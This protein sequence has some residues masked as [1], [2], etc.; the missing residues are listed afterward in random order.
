[1]TRPAADF[2]ELATLTAALCDGEITPPQAQRLE[3]LAGQSEAAR[4]YFLQYM[5]LHGE[6][7]WENGDGA[8]AGTTLCDQSN[9]V[10]PARAPSPSFHV[11]PEQTPFV[12]VAPR[13]SS[14]RQ[15]ASVGGRWL[16]RWAVTAA[17]LASVVWIVGGVILS[18]NPFADWRWPPRIARL[19]QTT[20]AQWAD[21]DQT[22]AFSQEL[23]A[24]HVLDLR[25]GLAEIECEGGARLVLQ[26][27]T[28][29]TLES[30]ERLV[31]HRGRIVAH[32]PPA[33]VGFTVQTPTAT[34]VDRGTDFGVVC[35]A[36]RSTEVHVF[37]GAVQVQPTGADAA[38][39]RTELMAG[40]AVRVAAD[41]ADGRL[42]V[43]R[44]PAASSLFV[45]DMPSAAAGSVAQ[46]RRIV[47]AH[48]NLIHHYTFEGATR[49]Q[50]YRDHR[51]EL[52]LRE[53]VMCDGRGGGNLR[54]VVP[55]FDATTNA[56]AP[57]RAE[58][59][60][61]S[62]GVGLE[63]DAMFEP[64]AEMTVELL[65]RFDA[66]QRADG[67]ICAAVAT[68][69]SQRQCG[70]LVAAADNGRPVQLL[71][72]E[73]T[74]IEAEDDFAFI[75]GDWYYM[76]A[77][78]RVEDGKTRVS[79][80]AANL[81]RHESALTRVIRDRLVPGTPPTSRLGI[82]KAFEA[83]LTH[84]YPWAGILD[85]VAIYNAVLDETTLG[86]HLRALIR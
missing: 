65:L 39:D 51:G 57:H 10:P 33:A 79:T 70:F 22:V 43:Q 66:P 19:G 61:K 1:M 14:G 77:T 53:I 26:G 44:M 4:W 71:D 20:D 47:A 8:R 7:Y 80:C 60:G 34:V 37:V 15:T 46:L 67:A 78:F 36:D 52:H 24:G 58:Q 41:P 75:P 18:F 23:S 86:E 76:A 50:R 35:D 6:L 82:G 16:W 2:D 83:N 28:R 59:N 63:S 13:A 3:E 54:D 29:L 84:A 31:L 11:P 5:Q 72:S 27:P 73:A 38:S 56:V 12:Q 68:R 45:R 69:E 48:P 64:P 40:Q 25:A 9:R 30:A 85:E 17:L 55:G 42:Q 74:W 62:N 32:V 81:S 49:D 21:G